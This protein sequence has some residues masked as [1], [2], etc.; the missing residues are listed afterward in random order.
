MDVMERIKQQVEG[1]PVVIYMKGT[2]QLPQCGFS[3]RAVEALKQCGHK[4]VYVNVLLDPEVFGGLPGYANWPTF[5]Q[6]YISGE[7]IGGCDITLELA[8]SGE[9]RQMVET[10]VAGAKE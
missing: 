3:S 1:N 6:V 10:A 9:L 5:P 8:A 7:L 2:P 4:F